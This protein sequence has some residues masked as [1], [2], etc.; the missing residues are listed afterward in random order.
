M[1]NLRKVHLRCLLDM[2]NTPPRRLLKRMKRKTVTSRL[3]LIMMNKRHLHQ[4]F[5]KRKTKMRWRTRMKTLK[6]TTMT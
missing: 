2:N 3:L 5:E 4:G 1:I 6:R